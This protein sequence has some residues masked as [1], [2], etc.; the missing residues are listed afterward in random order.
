MLVASKI[1]SEESIKKNLY[2]SIYIVFHVGI[3]VVGYWQLMYNYTH[4]DEVKMQFQGKIIYMVD[5]PF[6]HPH[7]P[8]NIKQPHCI[9]PLIL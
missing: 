6:P 3:L 7:H 2:K 8:P 1:L 4:V 5:L 9:V